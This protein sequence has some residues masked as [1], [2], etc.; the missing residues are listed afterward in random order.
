MKIKTLKRKANKSITYEL[1]H[2]KKYLESKNF[3]KTN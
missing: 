3:L 2:E 1:K